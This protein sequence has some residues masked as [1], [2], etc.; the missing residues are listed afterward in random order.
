MRQSSGSRWWCTTHCLRGAVVAGMMIASDSSLAQAQAATAPAG[1]PPA[2]T[3]EDIQAAVDRAALGTWDRFSARVSIRSQVVDAAGNAAGPAAPDQEVVWERSAS[4]GGWHTTLTLTGAARPK[5]QSRAGSVALPEPPTVVR[6][7]DDEDGT[8]P[9]FYT[10][11]GVQV[12]LP[13]SDR[14]AR[15]GISSVTDLR[16]IAQGA[17]T[18]P[19]GSNQFQWI[20]S[21][22]LSPATKAARVASVERAY[23]RRV[24]TVRGLAQ[25][26]RDDAEGRHEL[27]V[28]DVSGAAVEANRTAGGTLVSHTTFS[29]ERAVSGALVRRAVRVERTLPESTERSSSPGPRLITEFTYSN[30]R[31]DRKGGR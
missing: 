27:L 30:V 23:G 4:G 13:S 10:K 22:V 9:R 1:A 6:I 21:F 5:V 11:A 3:T 28:D 16:A 19:S 12:A 25:Y 31:L 8:S 24:G 2:V 15:L 26:L 17:T 18:S 7:E 20:Q 29:Y 14:L